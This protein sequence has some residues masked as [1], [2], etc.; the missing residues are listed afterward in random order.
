MN[1]VGCSSTSY[2]LLRRCRPGGWILKGLQGLRGIGVVAEIDEFAVA[3]LLD[4][5]KW[6]L[7]VNACGLGPRAP[8]PQ[9]DQLVARRKELLGLGD[10]V[11]PQVGHVL[12]EREH[13]RRTMKIAAAGKSVGDM[14]LKLGIPSVEERR[15]GLPKHSVTIPRQYHEFVGDRVKR[16]SHDQRSISRPRG[17]CQPRTGY[18]GDRLGA[19]FTSSWGGCERARRN[20]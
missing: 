15:I 10:R 17:G 18:S 6:Q 7:H 8:R 14:P 3:E 20:D 9:Y 1:S 19:L 11:F 12:E 2:R 5:C 16:R 13:L 4:V